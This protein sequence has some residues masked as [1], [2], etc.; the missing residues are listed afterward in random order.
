MGF[1]KVSYETALKYFPQWYLRDWWDR[2]LWNRVEAWLEECPKEEMLKLIKEN[3]VKLRDEWLEK[4]TDDH[5][6]LQSLKK[7]LPVY[8]E[9]DWYKNSPE[10][11]LI[12]WIK[13][14]EDRRAHV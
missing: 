13:S 6:L 5:T 14:E 3:L 7:E 4:S 1:I 9:P 8:L 11:D 10:E 12:S 2:E